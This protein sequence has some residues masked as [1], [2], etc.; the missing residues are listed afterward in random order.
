MIEKM[1]YPKFEIPIFTAKDILE[2]R[3]NDKLTT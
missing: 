1:D 2:Y 3:Q